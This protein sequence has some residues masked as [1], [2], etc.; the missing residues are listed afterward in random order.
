MNDTTPPPDDEVT[1]EE[2]HR[3]AIDFR[4]Y[5]RSDGLFEVVARLTDTKPHA[6]TPPA[7]SRTVAA[8]EPIHDIV[9]RVVFDA[10]MV[11]RAVTPGMQ[12]YPYRQCVAGGD[13]LQA[14]PG[15]V[16]GAGWTSEVRKRLPAGEV[17]THL[18]EI[19]VP[20]AS[21]AYQTMTQ[22][23]QHL[24]HA[25]DASGRPAKIDSCYAYGASRALVRHF[26]PE[27]QRPA[28]GED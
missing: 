25:T 19:L 26:W 22:F 14:L 20:L 27:H 18:R 5:R 21:A 7:E 28:Q 15:L 12:A 8:G 17:C 23:R 16:I 10:D 6:F 3:R 13:V 2:L 24:L 9:L 1:R 11:V 4:G